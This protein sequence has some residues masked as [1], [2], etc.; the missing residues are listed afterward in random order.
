MG[1]SERGDH[2]S[3]TKD[4][5]KDEFRRAKD[6]GSDPNLSAREAV[7]TVTGMAKDVFAAASSYKDACKQRK[8]AVAA[9]LQETRKKCGLKQQEVADR[10]GIHVITLSGYEVGRSEPN[11]EALVRLADVYGVS[12]DYLLCRTTSD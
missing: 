2:M 8:A 5:L 1:E 12:L 7:Q 6:I 3:E 4:Y 11:T 9:R 10:T